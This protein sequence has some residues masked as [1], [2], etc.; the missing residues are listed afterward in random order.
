MKTTVLILGSSGFLGSQL[1]RYF[2]ERGDRCVG[3][4]RSPKCISEKSLSHFEGDVA[5]EAQWPGQKIVINCV[6]ISSIEKCATNPDLAWEMNVRFASRIAAVCRSVGLPLA[7]ISTDGLFKSSGALGPHYFSKEDIA[8][9]VSE[10]GRTKLAAEIELK[11]IGWGH[12]CRLSFVGR[13][14]HSSRGLISFL[15]RQVR[16]KEKTIG[17]ADVWFN[18]LHIVQVVQS[19]D[20]L[21]KA[22]GGYSLNQFGS[23]PAMTKHEFLIQVIEAA[24]LNFPVQS[25]MRCDLDGA[26]NAPFDQS[27]QSD[28][29]FSA[30]EMIC[31]AAADLRFELGLV[32]RRD[33]L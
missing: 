28:L 16:R 8:D 3:Y 29:Q 14:S 22:G 9:P 19:I 6:A 18:P 5:E 21:L 31:L 10:Y 23:Y 4:A 2:S 11:N 33:Y 12:I 26:P 27:L 30:K 13:E 25:G 1:L 32:D 15:A 20:V 7:H 24:N 17:Y